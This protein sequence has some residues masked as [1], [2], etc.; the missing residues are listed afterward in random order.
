M[1]RETI[2]ST[3]HR[4]GYVTCECAAG[5]VTDFAVF[6]AAPHVVSG[7]AGRIGYTRLVTTEAVVTLYHTMRYGWLSESW[8]YGK[9]Q[10]R[11][12]QR[13]D[14]QPIVAKYP[15]SHYRCLL[16]GVPSP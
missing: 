15:L 14:H 4:V 10:S 6:V 9:Q 5:F 16:R 2:V 11:Q 13:S 3:G 1:T 12:D 7:Q 8:P